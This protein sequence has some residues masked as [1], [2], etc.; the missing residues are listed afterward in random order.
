M[1]HVGSR[2]IRRRPHQGS[3]AGTGLH[4]CHLQAARRL[5]RAERAC[6]APMAASALA[7]GSTP[8]GLGWGKGLAPGP[9]LILPNV[10]CQ[11]EGLEE[12]PDWAARPLPLPLPGGTAS[13]GSLG[14]LTAPHSDLV[15]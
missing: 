1:E 15:S 9:S 6:P 10:A 12:K 2:K 13:T 4:V 14:K 5:P 3:K 11:D 7:E 8:W